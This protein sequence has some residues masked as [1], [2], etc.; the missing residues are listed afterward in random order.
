MMETETLKFRERPSFSRGRKW[1]IGFQVVL[2]VLSVLAIGVMLNYLSHRHDHRF[3][4]SASSR[5]KLTPLT[6]QVLSGLTNRV[7]IIVFFDRREPL[8]GQVSTLAKEYEAHSPKIDL[9]FVDYRM[10]G[11]AETIRNQYKITSGGDNSRIIFD[12]GAQVRTVLETELSEFGISPEKEIKRTAFKGEQLFTSAILNITR[13]KPLVAYFFKG[14]GEHEI[15]DDDNQRGYSL[16]A[17]LL[18]NNN[19]ELKELGPLIGNDIPSNCSLLV[20]A[21][22]THALEPIELTKI[23]RYLSQGGRLFLMFNFEGI[24]VSTGLEQLLEKWNVEVGYNWVQ[25]TSQSQAGEQAIILTSNYGAH[26]IV[27]PMLRSSLK[28][29]TPRSIAQR[30]APGLSADAPKAV[31][32]FSSGPKGRAIARTR[33]GWQEEKTGVIPLAVAVERGAIQGVAADKGAT[34]IVVTGDSFFLSNLAFN[35]AANSDFANLA[36]NWLVNRDSLLND[37]GPSPVSEYEIL[38]TE[39]Q[40]AQLRWLFLA[41]IPG[42]VLAFGLFVWW[43]RRA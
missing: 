25:D 23:D 9:E 20:I 4:L 34:R 24:T 31:E 28:L 18:E 43:R 5:H 30:R 39:R 38:L 2:S 15:G 40:M 26:P 12:S 16:F 21:G 27:R 36:V 10:P 33:L 32:L 3:Y 8:F 14:H 11:R 41:I 13:N 19:I 42:I 1:K 17:R 7:K 35:Q 29:V 37:I 6:L 22:P